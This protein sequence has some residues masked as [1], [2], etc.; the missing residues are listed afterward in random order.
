MKNTNDILQREEFRQ[1]PFT[2]PEGYFASLEDSLRD[3]V[4]A[5]EKKPAGFV[6]VLKPALMMACSFAVILGLGY[7]ILSMTGS[8]SSQ[9]AQM[10][11]YDEIAA[12]VE[13]FNPALFEYLDE[14]DIESYQAQFTP[15]DEEIMEYFATSFTDAALYNYL[16]SIQ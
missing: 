9:Q 13:N 2:V 8:F 10:S 7:G 15:S 12:A 16:A 4:F 1:N 11:E 5:T 3:K 14:I 6:G